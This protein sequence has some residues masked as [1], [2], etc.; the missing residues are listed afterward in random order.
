MAASAPAG[1]EA[2]GMEV[3]DREASQGRSGAKKCPADNVLLP[4]EVRHHFTLVA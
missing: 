1:R 3:F 4:T 2:V